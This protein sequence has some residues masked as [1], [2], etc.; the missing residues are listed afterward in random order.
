L[1]FEPR[2]H[3]ALRFGVCVGVALPAEDEFPLPAALHADEAAFAR[4][5]PRARRAGWVGGRVALRAALAALGRPPAGALLATP[6]GAPAL[7][8]GLAGSISHKR[9]LAVALAAERSAPS[10]PTLGIDVEI[11][12]RLHQDISRHVLT[13]DELAALASLGA[14]AREAEVLRRFS[15]KEAIYKALDPWVQR[16][17]SFQEVAIAPA[18][19]ARAAA[20]LALEGGEVRLALKGGEGPFTVELEDASDGELVLFAARVGRPAV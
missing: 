19:G 18:A 14:A 6:R 5:L 16:M 2:F 3:R 9:E 1:A 17:V 13:P 20:R 7:P 11:R 10:A 15:A 8:P 12:H 4:S